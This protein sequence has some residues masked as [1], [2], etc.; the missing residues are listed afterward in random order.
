MSAWACFC[1]WMNIRQR[2]MS[3]VNYIINVYML[4]NYYSFSSEML[5]VPRI[6]GTTVDPPPQR[7]YKG[8]FSMRKWLYI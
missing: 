4:T 6:V 2:I 8:R 3:K 7:S 1:V 5:G